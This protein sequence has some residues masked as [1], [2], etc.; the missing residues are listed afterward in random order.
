MRYPMTPI[1]SGS[2]ALPGT[3]PTYCRTSRKVSG[4][5]DFPLERIP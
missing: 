3:A 5:A 2:L 4:T 1:F